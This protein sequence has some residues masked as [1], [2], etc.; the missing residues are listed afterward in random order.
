MSVTLNAG[1]GGATCGTD[2]VT[3]TPNTDYQI[4]KLGF[5]ATG[6]A[7]TQAS[8]TNPLPTA[9]YFSGTAASVNSGNLDAG[10]LRVVLAT[11]QPSLSNAIPVT[12]SGA[13]TVTA[14]A[15][16]GTFSISG[17]LADA[18]AFTRGTT[19]TTPIAGVAETSAPSLTTGKAAS[20]SLNLSGALRV[21]GSG[22][23]QPVSGTFWQ[24]TQPVSGTVTANQGGTWTVQPGN[25]ANTT[26]WLMQ[27]VPAASGGLSSTTLVSAASNNLTQVKASA[28]QIYFLQ[29]G[30]LNASPRY[31]KVFFK[32]SASVTMGTTAADAQFM[33]PGDTAGAGFVI[34]IDKGIGASG[35]G[36]TVAVT[37][38]ISLTDNTAISASEVCL[39]VGYA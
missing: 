18:A 19:V 22:V 12:Q 7:P 39:T 38:G 31:V 34:D 27:P 25:T 37:G 26:P 2:T 32:P 14:N 23:T 10:T 1:S 20:L 28:G 11:N 13:W 30:N 33:I 35:T 15:G 21:D 4:V 3:G 6:I 17:Q 36:L 16:T 29:A 24:A 8:A 5:S 9:A